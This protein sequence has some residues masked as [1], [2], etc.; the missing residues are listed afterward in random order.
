M[1]TNESKSDVKDHQWFQNECIN[2]YKYENQETLVEQLSPFF[3]L[4]LL[5]SKLF[6]FWSVACLMDLL[7]SLSISSHIDNQIKRTSK[8]WGDWKPF[9]KG[10]LNL[11]LEDD[12]WLTSIYL[13]CILGYRCQGNEWSLYMLFASHFILNRLALTVDIAQWL[14]LLILHGEMESV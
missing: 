8:K 2:N 10:W 5:L 11:L 9:A 4:L 1:R 14:S 3:M 13:K 7:Y 6:V 12:Q